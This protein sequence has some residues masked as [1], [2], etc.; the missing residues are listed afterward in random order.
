MSTG[1]GPLQRIIPWWR[2]PRHA[3]WLAWPIFVVLHIGFQ[4]METFQ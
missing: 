3:F 4:T 1:I 2:P